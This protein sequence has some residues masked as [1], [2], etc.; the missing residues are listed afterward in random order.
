VVVSRTLQEDAWP[1]VRRRSG[2]RCSRAMRAIALLALLCAPA[3]AFAQKVVRYEPKASDLKY[4][5][6][7]AKP[8]ATVKPGEIIDTRTFLT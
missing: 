6:G 2:V 4:V 3:P 7:V 8:V 1:G 5:F